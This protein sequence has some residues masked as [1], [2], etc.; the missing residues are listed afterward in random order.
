MRRLVTN[1]ISLVKGDSNVATT[2]IEC[3]AGDNQYLLVWDGPWI[4]QPPKELNDIQGTK[5][6]KTLINCLHNLAK[7]NN[8]K[9]HVRHPQD[10]NEFKD[11]M[12]KLS[13]S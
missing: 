1:K 9:I 10:W 6:A 2:H 4:K 13:K 12:H 7:K 8:L 11:S 3:I 5:G